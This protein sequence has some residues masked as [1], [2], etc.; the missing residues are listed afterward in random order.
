MADSTT[1]NLLLT[2]PE[3]GASTDTWGTKLNA[4]LD[5][6]DAL[7]DAGPLLKVTRGGTGVGT[8]TGSGNNVLSTSPTL[9]TP[10]L[11]TPSSATLT[12]ATGLPIATGVSGL[13]TGVA[14]FLA[15]PSSANLA[16]AVSDETG[17]GALVFANSPTLVTPALGTP[18]SGV[19]TNLTGTASI[20]ING[21]VGATTAS[22][23]AF[24][25]LTTSSTVTHNG[26]TA[27]GVAFLNSSKVLTTGS[28]LTYNGSNFRVAGTDAALIAGFG[29]STKGV[30]IESNSTT[31]RLSG[32][33]SGFINSF[34]PLDV[35]GSYLTFSTSTTERM[36]LTS[37]GLGIGTSSPSQKLTV[38]GGIASTTGIS[39]LAASTAFFDFNGGN[40]RFAAVSGSTGT[41]APIL[42]SQYSSNGSVGRDAMTLDSSGNLGL[43]VTPSAWGSTYRVFQNGASSFYN[44][45]ANTVVGNNLYNDGSNLR[46]YSNGGAGL[47]VQDSSSQHIW[48]NA[49]SGTTGNAASLTQA[50]T[51][52]AAGN[53]G[54]GT[55]SPAQKVDVVG[56]QGRIR[57]DPSNVSGVCVINFTDVAAANFGVGALSASEI[58]FNTNSAERARI[59]SGGDLLVGGTSAVLSSKFLSQFD[60]NSHNGAILNETASAASATFLGFTLSGTAIGSVARVGA[61]SAVI[62]NTTSDQRLKSN[63]QTAEPVLEKLMQVQVRQYD[64]TVGDLHQEYGFIAQELEPVLS[65][66]VT[67]GKTEEDMWQLD[68]SRLTPHLV[69][70][71]QEL[72]AEFDAYKASHP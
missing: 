53:L 33:D 36:R 25:T 61:T 56:T 9:V 60:G 34:E 35:N 37:T 68:Y 69:K 10:V 57:L 58:R 51:L 7:F 8:S 54:V 63:I 18:T 32:V 28:A 70:A 47:Y 45:G 39:A 20:N 13:G 48:Y 23:G 50:M 30:R 67:K 42:F 11:G 55:T 21:T 40:A 43:G 17:T 14:T 27:N 15:T 59:T 6:I 46:Y 26:G 12:N 71:I 44:I 29:G 5:T 66:V 62:Y 41:A 4:D 65:G 3:V 2:K 72:K 22:T 1:T 49:P 38:A 24:T 31:S 19:V 16:A 52:T 64:W